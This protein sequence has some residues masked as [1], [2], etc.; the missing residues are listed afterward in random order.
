MFEKFITLL[1]ITLKT[2]IA[3]HEVINCT[4]N[5]WEA[6]DE[7]HEIFKLANLYCTAKLLLQNQIWSI[8]SK[9]HKQV[10]LKL[11]QICLCE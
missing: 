3:T 5:L 6:N 9:A 1:V 11:S 2:I 7:V 8:W 10:V 4:L